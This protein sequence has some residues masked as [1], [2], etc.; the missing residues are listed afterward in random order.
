MRI[1]L[2]LFSLIAAL[3]LP[4]LGAMDA[5]ASPVEVPP[6]HEAPSHDVPAHD[7]PAPGGHHGMDVSPTTDTS[8]AQ[9]PAKAMKIMACCIAC[10]AAQPAV[11]DAAR[12]SVRRPTAAPPLHAA[13][14]GRTVSPE[15]DPPRA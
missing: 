6:C 4:G 13:V 7:V 10:V 9:A 8:P 12:Q 14:S 11:P 2:A 5:F 3:T 1:L 15:P